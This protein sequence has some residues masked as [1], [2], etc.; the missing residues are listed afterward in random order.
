M[1]D[2]DTRLGRLELEEAAKLLREVNERRRR[3]DAIERVL[4][5]ASRWAF[6]GMGM[7]FG[8]TLVGFGRWGRYAGLAILFPILVYA[9]VLSRRVARA[10]RDSP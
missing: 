2:V 3:T 6:F 5:R 4:V 1:T 7:G 8:M 9:H 10:L